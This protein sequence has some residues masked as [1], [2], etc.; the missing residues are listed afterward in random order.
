MAVFGLHRSA[1]HCFKLFVRHRVRLSQNP[2]SFM[3]ADQSTCHT[4]PTV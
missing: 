2:R 4:P 1:G 3:N